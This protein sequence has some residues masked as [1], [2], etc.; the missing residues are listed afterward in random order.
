MSG[1][2]FYCAKCNTGNLGGAC[3]V[4]ARNTRRKRGPTGRICP[5][6]RSAANR[7]PKL[8]ERDGWACHLCG[9]PIDPR[10]KGKRKATLDHV[11]PRS[12]GGT[13]ALSNLKLAHESCNQARGNALLE[14]AA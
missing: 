6:P 5:R 10:A 13:G 4:C 8:A 1:L 12:H 11:L 2:L 9:E 3:Q 7:I 14:D